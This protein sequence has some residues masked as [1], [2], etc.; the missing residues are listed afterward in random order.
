MLLHEDIGDHKLNFKGLEASKFTM[1]ARLLQALDLNLFGH[2]SED[3]NILLLIVLHFHRIHLPVFLCFFLSLLI[4]LIGIFQ[5]PLP[6]DLS[7]QVSLY[8][9]HFFWDIG[10]AKNSRLISHFLGALLPL[11]FLLF[12]ISS[13]LLEF[14]HVFGSP[15]IHFF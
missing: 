1:S 6:L 12:Q 9:F 5:L 14:E 11:L 3:G 2:Q 4:I 13:L 10:F 15:G 8:H 7:E